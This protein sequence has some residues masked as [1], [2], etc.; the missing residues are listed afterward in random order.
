MG[1]PEWRDAMSEETDDYNTVPTLM[2]DDSRATE[3]A[4]TVEAVPE[5]KK[6]PT[7]RKTTAKK[8]TTK[9]TA[10]KKRTATARKKAG[11]ISA[12]P[13]TMSESLSKTT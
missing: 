10:T 11:K 8:R 13:A 1:V 9:R 12:T 2:A 5:T 3:D 4:P 6:A 7:K